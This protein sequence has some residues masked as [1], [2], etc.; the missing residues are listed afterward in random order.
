MELGPRLPVIVLAA[1]GLAACGSGAGASD[2]GRGGDPKAFRLMA[3]LSTAT[4]TSHRPT[5]H[6][7]LDPASDG[8]HVQICRDRACTIEVT[9]FDA[10]GASGA[11]AAA[12]PTGVLFWRAFPRRTAAVDAAVVDAAV[13]DAAVVDAAP[14][15]TAPP[16][17][18]SPTATW[19]F[20]VGAGDAPV[21][22]SWGTFLDLNG[23]GYADL[24]IGAYV[25]FGGPAGLAETPAVILESSP[26]TAFDFENLWASAGD[27]NGDGY[28]DLVVLDPAGPGDLNAA[29]VYLGSAT[30][31]S[32][33]PSFKL[34]GNY[35]QDEF[36]N[37]AVAGVGDLN[38]DGYADIVIGDPDVIPGA[39]YIYWGSAAGP[40][41]K[42][43][44]KLT[45]TAT[46]F[47]YSVAGAGDVNGDGYAD[48]LVA[49]SSWQETGT[50]PAAFGYLFLGGPGGPLVAPLVALTQS[51]GT[52]LLGKSLAGAG[53][54]NGDGYADLLVGAPNG[55]TGGAFLY[56]GG[57]TGPSGKPSLALNG[58][59]SAFGTGVAG[60]GDV[61]GDGYDDFVVSDPESLAVDTGMSSSHLDLAL[62]FLGGPAGPSATASTTLRNPDPTGV[63]PTFQGPLGSGDFNGDGDSDFCAPAVGQRQLEYV[64]Y[65][66]AGGLPPAPG[67]KLD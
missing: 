21:D 16:P 65:G 57:P 56:L 23:D 9:S 36:F 15:P 59:D 60:V 13:V 55:Q 29:Y 10:L 12:L 30:G 37:L 14:P 25:H 1:V 61:N 43:D 35:A 67:A 34:A 5:L 8:A 3:P 50:S 54:V 66:A 4:V 31:P 51:D 27:V 38:G 24:V 49:D 53:D 7:H 58:A 39:V 48:L 26:G 11:P 33:S 28:G 32:A 42:Y 44:L 6:W 40:S 63:L 45:G 46:S 52:A 64:Y 22:S 17:T 2:G 41:S 19:E 62:V 47:G 20:K 18:S